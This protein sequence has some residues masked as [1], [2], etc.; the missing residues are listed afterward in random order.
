MILW[1][2]FQTNA[3]DVAL[4]S[5]RGEPS[6][7]RSTSTTARR[8]SSVQLVCWQKL[9]P[10]GCRRRPAFVGPFELAEFVG[11]PQ[12]RACAQVQGVMARLPG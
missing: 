2:G 1:L 6:L 5:T 7:A 4:E 10:S 11:L 3:K 12:R 9:A 8:G